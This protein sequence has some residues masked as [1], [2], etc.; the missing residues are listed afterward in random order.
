MSN[1]LLEQ[2]VYPDEIYT[3]IP[4]ENAQSCRIRHLSKKQLAYS[5]KKYGKPL[6]YRCQKLEHYAQ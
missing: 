2:R 6:C 5:Q 4:C 3:R 1:Q